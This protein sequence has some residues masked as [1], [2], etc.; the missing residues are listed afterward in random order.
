MQVRILL[1][2][3]DEITAEELLKIQVIHNTV[4]TAAK[5]PFA[6]AFADDI[7]TNPTAYKP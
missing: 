3:A 5:K 4:T 2:K 7:V 6:Y 1:N